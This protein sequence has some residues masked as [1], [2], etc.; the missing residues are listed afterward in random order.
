MSFVAARRRARPST[1]G[2]TIGLPTT[3]ATR[4]SRGRIL[5]LGRMCSLPPTPTGTIGTPSFTARYAAPSNSGAISGP[6][7]GALGEHRHRLASRELGLE[8]PERAAVGGAPLDLDRAERGEQP[9][10]ARASGTALPWRGSG[11]ALRDERARTAR[12]GSSGATARR[13]TRP[14]AGRSPCRPRGRGTRP[15]HTL[16][17][18]ARARTGRRSSRPPRR[19]G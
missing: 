18:D 19:L 16:E 8:H 10:R 14:T 15:E 12:R 13:C 7:P 4:C 1:A 3:T 17:H 11:R 5:P 9:V 2:G 6:L